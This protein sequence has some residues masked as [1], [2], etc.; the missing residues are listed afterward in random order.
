MKLGPRL[1]VA[2]VLL[3]VASGAASAAESVPEDKD[4]DLIPP[5]A[6]TQPQQTSPPPDSSVAAGAVQ[7]IFLEGAFTQ[8]WL[9]GGL[10]PAPRPPPPRWEERALLDVR[11][12]WHGGQALGQ[13]YSGRF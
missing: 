2:V 8:S 11:S 13:T 7:K 3:C 12:E 1:R 4:L 9:Q 10:V 5:P 6:Q